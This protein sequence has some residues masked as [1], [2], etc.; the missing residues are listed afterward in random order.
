MLQHER[1]STHTHWETLADFASEINSVYFGSF[2]HHFI[3]PLIET[4]LEQNSPELLRP[5]KLKSSHSLLM[6]TVT[7]NEMP[8]IHT[9]NI[10]F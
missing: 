2:I 4:A 10:G 6:E 3:L 8:L 1:N 9:C 7:H 5:A